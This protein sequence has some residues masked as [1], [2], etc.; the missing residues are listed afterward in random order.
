VVGCCV[1]SNGGRVAH[2]Q[3]EEWEAA[4]CAESGLFK[5]RMRIIFLF[6]ILIITHYEIKA[7]F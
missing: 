3:S 4:N 2:A 6:I 1:Q 7:K 5:L